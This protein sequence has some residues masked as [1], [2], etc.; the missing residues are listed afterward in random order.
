MRLVTFA[1]MIFAAP[2][3]LA[4]R[5]HFGWRIGSALIVAA[6]LPLIVPP[7][8]GFAEIPPVKAY[9]A[10]HMTVL[11]CAALMAAVTIPALIWQSVGPRSQRI[12]PG[13]IGGFIGTPI[14]LT[15]LVIDAA[16]IGVLVYSRTDWEKALHPILDL[17]AEEIR[18]LGV[19]AIAALILIVIGQ[20]NGNILPG[21]NASERGRARVRNLWRSTARLCAG[22]R[23][24]RET[25]GAVF[26]RRP[27]DLQAI[28]NG[29]TR[30]R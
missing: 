25:L 9:V 3:L 24:S 23:P 18:H 12:A 2:L 10:R 11:V 30:Q 29:A 1:L 6:I 13:D 17:R 27:A 20:I 19:M 14:T 22:A 15:T 26:S 4:T 28:A 8:L 5:S 21:W 7:F 16:R